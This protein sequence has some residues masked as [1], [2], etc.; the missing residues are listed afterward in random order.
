METPEES[1]DR[2]LKTT[3]VVLVKNTKVQNAGESV[4]KMGHMLAFTD[5][6]RTDG[7]SISVPGRAK[8]TLCG[9]DTLLNH[10]DVKLAHLKSTKCK[11][12]L[13]LPEWVFTIVEDSAGKRRMQNA[14]RMQR[15]RAKVKAELE[16]RKTE[17]DNA[18]MAV[19]GGLCSCLLMLSQTNAHSLTSQILDTSLFAP[20]K[21]QLLAQGSKLRELDGEEYL[22]IALDSSNPVQDILPANLVKMKGGIAVELPLTSSHAATVRSMVICFH[23]L[24]R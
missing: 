19:S 24:S 12:A 22:V 13:P 23:S 6:S 11:R 1:I 9:L 5:T 3:F 17:T 14:Q 10:P 15:K 4:L 20:V 8:C 16:E 21:E 2:Y 18:E 7:K